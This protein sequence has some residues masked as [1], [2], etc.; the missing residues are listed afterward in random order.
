MVRLAGI[1]TMVQ[2]SGFQYD[3]LA[4]LLTLPIGDDVNVALGVLD[5]AVGV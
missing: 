2:R 4:N 5:Q 3:I 1:P